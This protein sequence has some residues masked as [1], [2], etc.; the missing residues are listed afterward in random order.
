MKVWGGRDFNG[1]EHTFSPGEYTSV[2]LE[3]KGLKCDDVS[4]LE[5]IGEF[6]EA[7]V[8]E[9][10]DFNKLHPGWSANFTQGRYA[11][12]DLVS[13]GAKNNDISS[14]RLVSNVPKPKPERHSVDDIARPGRDVVT[15]AV[16]PETWRSAA[17]PSAVALWF[18]LL[19]W[20]A[21]L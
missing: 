10:G 7:V 6:C 5:V 15:K 17:P 3:Y 16:N 1:W 2:D 13:R 12:Q 14:F 21:A 11:A 20:R 8:F 9:Y 4:S 18:A 19:A